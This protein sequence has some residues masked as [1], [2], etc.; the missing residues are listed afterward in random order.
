MSKFEF[1]NGAHIKGVTAD[2]AGDELARIYEEK[3]EL[4]AV[5]VHVRSAES[6]KPIPEVVTN[7]S[8]F[9][10]VL[11]TATKRVEEAQ[12]ALSVLESYC[13]EDQAPAVRELQMVIRSTCK[14][15][16]A[17]AAA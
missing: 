2:A 9:A 4:T 10:E 6:Y 12:H 17:L 11:L 14:T 13:N 1:R 5:Y 8:V 16:N 15:L 7:I 3:G